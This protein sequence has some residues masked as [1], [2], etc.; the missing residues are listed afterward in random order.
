MVPD[1][2]ASY[3]THPIAIAELG[4]ND[5]HHLLCLDSDDKASAVSFPSGHLID[6]NRDLNLDTRV[7]LQPRQEG[8]VTHALT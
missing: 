1:Q 5:N 4:E 8:A 7:M 3:I 6:P 2:G